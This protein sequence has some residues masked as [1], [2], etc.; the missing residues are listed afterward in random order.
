MKTIGEIL[1]EKRLSKKYSLEKIEDLSKIKKEFIEAIENCKWEDLPEYSTVLGFVKII[2]QYLGIEEKKSVALLKR[3]YLLKNR[4]DVNPKPDISEKFSW[5]PRITFWF[6]FTITFLL[7]IF[8]L[9]FQYKKFISPPILEVDLPKENQI[10]K[11]N[12]VDVIGKTD[13]DAV[14]TVNNQPVLTSS[15]GDFEAEIQITKDTYEIT[16][17]AVSRSGKETIIRRIIKPEF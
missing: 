6:G 2:S 13:G 16:I 8:Y 7:V 1:K 9:V 11:E 12:I 17:K 3:D 5:S 14:V 15:E 4:L 10:V